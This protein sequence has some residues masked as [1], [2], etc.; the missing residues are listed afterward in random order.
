L[1]S[2]DIGANEIR[3]ILDAPIHMR[4]SRKVDEQ[5][6]FDFDRFQDFIGLTDIAMNE[7]VVWV[8]SNLGQVLRIPRVGQL[9]KIDHL[10]VRMTLHPMPN[11][12]GADESGTTRDE[13]L[14]F[15]LPEIS[16]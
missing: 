10:A 8:V 1:H 14:H 16:R 11:E 9:V 13:Y 6:G 2:H 15:S 12:V 5:I 7:S 3:R 4:L